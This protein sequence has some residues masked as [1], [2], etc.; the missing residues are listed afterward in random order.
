[1]VG[2]LVPHLLGGGTRVVKACME[3]KERSGCQVSA[4]RGDRLATSAAYFFWL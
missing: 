1:V 2:R 3:R 4:P